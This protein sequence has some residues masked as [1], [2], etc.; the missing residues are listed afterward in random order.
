MFL[1]VSRYKYAIKIINNLGRSRKL[2]L[3]RDHTNAPSNFKFRLPRVAYQLRYNWNF[4]CNFIMKIYVTKTSSFWISVSSWC[5]RVL[6][7][8]VCVYGPF[9]HGA[10]KLDMSTNEHCLQHFSLNFNACPVHTIFSDMI[11][12][13]AQGVI[14]VSIQSLTLNYFQTNFVIYKT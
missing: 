14:G 6:C 4:D 10:L 2:N 12:P 5:S 3:A 9:C 8:S 1:L 13:S 11:F 7:C